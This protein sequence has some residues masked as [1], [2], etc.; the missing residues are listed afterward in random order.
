MRRYYSEKNTD[1]RRR[2]RVVVPVSVA[3]VLSL[4]WV[5]EDVPTSVLELQFGLEGPTR[6]VPEITLIPGV[7][8]FE[9]SR[10]ESRFRATPAVDVEDEEIEVESEEQV[11]APK[12]EQVPVEK[13]DDTVAPDL[14]TETVRVYPSHTAAPYSENYVILD[15][16]RPVYPAAELKNGIEGDVTIELFVNEGG[17]VENAWVMVATGSR[18]FETASLEAVRQFRFKPPIVDGKPSSM[19]ISFQIRFRIMN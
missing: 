13:P 15:M 5:T 12:I 7:D 10:E 4:L 8:M 1:Y 16:T 2:M 18:N 3:L 14:D 19:W 17:A 11:A 6:I 9:D